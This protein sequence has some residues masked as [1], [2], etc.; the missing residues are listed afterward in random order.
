MACFIYVRLPIAMCICKWS[1]AWL[2]LPQSGDRTIAP[3][4][5]LPLQKPWEQWVQE[6]GQLGVM[7]YLGEPSA[8]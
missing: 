7:S 4:A 6:V 2:T 1:S 3:R 8:L 5:D